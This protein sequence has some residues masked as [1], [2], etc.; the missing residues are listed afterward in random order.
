MG[1]KTISA[2]NS[3]LYRP[4]LPADPVPLFFKTRGGGGGV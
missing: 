1:S 3:F 2:L 4:W